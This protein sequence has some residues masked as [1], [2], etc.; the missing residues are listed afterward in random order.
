[1]AENTDDRLDKISSL[2]EKTAGGVDTIR[3]EVRDI[4]LDI[5][6]IRGEMTQMRGEMT[7]MRG[8]V[9]EIRSDL[10]KVEGKVDLL[11]GQFRDVATMAI[12]DHQRIDKLEGRVGVL[13][14]EAN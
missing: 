10:R 1:M 7:E 11:S 9:H 14:S 5:T 4:R 6:Q 3:L 13:E 2:L 8:E 12:G